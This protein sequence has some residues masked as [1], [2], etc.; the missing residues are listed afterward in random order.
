MVKFA[1]LYSVIGRARYFCPPHCTVGRELGPRITCSQIFE[2]S[3]A[4]CTLGEQKIASAERNFGPFSTVK[5]LTNQRPLK[6]VVC[7]GQYSATN[8]RHS[9]IKENAIT[10]P[11]FTNVRFSSHH[12]SNGTLCFI[13][14]LCLA[15]T[16]DIVR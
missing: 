10:P 6:P 7:V 2:L 11:L 8:I 16:Q 12:L 1:V 5:S 13:K 3:L 14:P 9:P 15:K 4:V